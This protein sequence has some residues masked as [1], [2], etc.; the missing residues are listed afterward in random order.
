MARIPRS[1][2]RKQR[3]RGPLLEVVDQHG[4]EQELLNCRNRMPHRPG[5]A[6]NL[7]RFPPT[8]ANARAG[9]HQGRIDPH[10]Q[11]P[12]GSVPIPEHHLEGHGGTVLTLH[13]QVVSEGI[14]LCE[15]EDRGIHP[16][17]DH[18][19][20]ACP[21]V[22]RWQEGVHT[23]LHGGQDVF[24]LGGASRDPI[25]PTAP[26]HKAGQSDGSQAFP[27]TRHDSR[28]A[29]VRGKKAIASCMTRSGCCTPSTHF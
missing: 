16:D 19:G 6:P 23:E 12:S 5:I 20:S 22:P 9:N 10:M 28:S 2:V 24:R 17:R 1:G 26:K 11:P 15:V 13:D 8:Q 3:A 7:Q 21:A 25:A 18:G 27:T 4:I 29:L 14:R